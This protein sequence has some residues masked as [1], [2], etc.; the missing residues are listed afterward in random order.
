MSLLYDI[1][2]GKLSY[3]VDA[4]FSPK[5]KKSTA[6]D[7]SLELWQAYRSGVVIGETKSQ[8]TYSASS[9]PSIYI[10]SIPPWLPAESSSMATFVAVIHPLFILFSGPRVLCSLI[11]GHYSTIYMS[12][13][14]AFASV[15]NTGNL[16]IATPQYNKLDMIV[17]LEL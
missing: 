4:E 14:V 7:F 16:F 3:I 17:V 8:I 1:I 2:K 6:C 15:C 11:S 10:N 9:Q 12:D 13:A 5:E